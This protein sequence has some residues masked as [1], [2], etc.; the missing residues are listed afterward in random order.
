[1]Q[2]DDAWMRYGSALIGSM[3]EVLEETDQETHP[4][5]LE[6]ADYWLS[7]GLA[8]GLERAGEAAPL[9]ELIESHEDDQAELSRDAE[10]FCREALG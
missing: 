7:L 4:W 5:L 10:A 1:M 2:Q 9:L 8:I 3:A 6:T